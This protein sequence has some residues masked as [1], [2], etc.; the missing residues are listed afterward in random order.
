MRRSYDAGPSANNFQSIDTWN[1][2]L[3]TTKSNIRLEDVL[4]VVAA[5]HMGSP[6]THSAHVLHDRLNYFLCYHTTYV[7]DQRYAFN[8]RDETINILRMAVEK[9]D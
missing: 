2:P 4:H 6:F 9:P 7:P 3:S 1:R 5:P 8:V